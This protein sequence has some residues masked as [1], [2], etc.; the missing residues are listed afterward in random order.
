MRPNLWAVRNPE[1]WANATHD[2]I[3]NAW[4]G[5]FDQYALVAERTAQDAKSAPMPV[6]RFRGKNDKSDI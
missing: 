2:D 1:I 6:R 4:I 5:V 3:A